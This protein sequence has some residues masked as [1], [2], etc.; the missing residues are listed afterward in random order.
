MDD[1]ID[2]A[3]GLLPDSQLRQLRRARP[4]VVRHAQGSYEAVFEPAQ[5]GALG[6]AERAALAIRIA[7][8]NEAHTLVEHYRALLR[9]LDPSG[10][11]ADMVVLEARSPEEPRFAAMLAHVDLV[12]KA[13]G[14]ATPENLRKL[15]AQGLTAS[16][17]VALSQL[18]ALVNYQVRVVAALRLM[19]EVA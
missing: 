4:D 17:I 6:R 18:V 14:S 3:A 10:S 7:L 9:R 15:E 11:L 5:E 8:L 16:D 13:P 12:T 1:V 2:E 19:G